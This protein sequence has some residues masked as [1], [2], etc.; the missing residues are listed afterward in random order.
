V[1]GE[2]PLQREKLYQLLHKGTRWCYQKPGW[3]GDFDNC[4]WD[5]LG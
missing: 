1:L 5:I 3:F 2:D 4:L